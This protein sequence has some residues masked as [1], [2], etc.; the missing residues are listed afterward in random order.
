MLKWRK[1]ESGN[2]IEPKGRAVDA[3]GQTTMKATPKESPSTTHR[4]SAFHGLGF[5]AT[6]QVLLDEV[7]ALYTADD[8]PW[9]IGYSGGEDST[10]ILQLVWT[11][12]ADLPR[13]QRGKNVYV[14]STDT[15]V[16]NP[17]VSLWVANPTIS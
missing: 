6:L 12:V 2:R 5:H 4:V 9:I 1:A 11:A 17:I 15:I 3:L 7:R 16:E 10:A 8:I 13:D 14:I